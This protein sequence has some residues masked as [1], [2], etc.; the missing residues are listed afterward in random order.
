MKSPAVILL[1][2]IVSTVT[3]QNIDTVEPIVR[4]VNSLDAYGYF[5]FSVVLHRV[6]EGSST[7]LEYLQNTRIIV[8]APNGTATNAEVE[9]TGVLFVC[10]VAQGTC[11]P[12]RGNNNGFDRRLYDVED[13]ADRDQKDNQFLGVSMES[14]DNMFIVCAHRF[15]DRGS[16]GDSRNPLGKCFYTE[17]RALEDFQEFHP[18]RG[19]SSGVGNFGVCQAGSSVALADEGDGNIAIGV[20]APGSY[21][22]RGIIFRRSSSGELDE[23]DEGEGTTSNGW[24]GYSMTKGHI[25]DANREDFIVSVTRTLT[26]I[27]TVNI[28]TNTDALDIVNE[29]QQYRGIQIG[30][31]Y[32]F[33]LA[34]VDLNGDGLDELLVG[35]PMYSR[36]GIPEVGRVYIYRN[37]G[38]NLEFFIHLT[39]PTIEEY[40]RF[41]HSITNLGDINGDGLEDVAIGAPFGKGSGTVYIYHGSVADT[42]SSLTPQQVIVG[43]EITESLTAV[44]SPKGFGYSLASGLDVDGNGL[45]DLVIGAYE[46]QQVFLLRSR[47]V[48]R[49]TITLTSNPAIVNLDNTTCMLE[50]VNYACFNVTA[51]TTFPGGTIIL[52]D[53]IDLEF[54]FIGDRRNAELGLEQRIF[55]NNVNQEINQTV[56]RMLSKGDETCVSETVYVKNGIT[57]RINGFPIELS[58]SGP[59]LNSINVDG[60]PNPTN[61]LNVPTVFV[62]GINELQV[63]T[64]K[65]CEGFVCV[66]D[67]EL[68][69]LNVSYES[70]SGDPPTSLVVGMV[71]NFNVWMTFSNTNEDAFLSQLSFTIPTAQFQFIRIEP[72]RFLITCSSVVRGNETVYTCLIANPLGMDQNRTLAVRLQPTKLLT[73]AEGIINLKFSA[74]SINEEMPNTLQDNN[75]TLP[76]ELSAIADIFIDLAQVDPEQVTYSTSNISSSSNITDVTDLGPRINVSFVIRNS[77]PSTV[78]NIQLSIFWPLQ[79]PDEDLLYYLYPAQR[80]GAGSSTIICETTFINPRRFT[81]PSNEVIDE[82]EVEGGVTTEGK[83]R[84]RRSILFE[85]RKR[86][87][88]KRQE[89]D[90]ISD[91]TINCRTEPDLCVNIVCNILQLGN[92]TAR[93]DI[94]SHLHEEYFQSRSDRFTFIPYANLSIIGSSYIRQPDIHRSDEAEVQI[95]AVTSVPS[96]QGNGSVPLWIIIVPIV[97]GLLFFAVVAVILYFVGFFRLKSKQ[98]KE[99]ISAQIL[100]QQQGGETP[101]DEFST[102]T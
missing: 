22:W 82:D 75:F 17:N 13:N 27:G 60:N 70:S 62:S 74:T 40:T 35:A 88:Q 99:E 97:L 42:I 48:A 80:T 66:P 87:L 96:S 29:N 67:L 73:G 54:T 65:D 92:T 43:S 16:S 72:R 6:G 76:I 101:Y 21:S 85:R 39:A 26:Y 37:V 3:A 46:S 34:A 102:S 7:F 51:C 41:G 19:R 31:Y 2:A 93:V 47:A 28:V 69:F 79:P 14:Q 49:V 71:T 84:R 9:N 98:K 78:P 61:L 77:G 55:F 58:I 23:M 100:E 25:T 56:S 33:S 89:V 86:S 50:S 24:Q 59:E 15:I 36:T 12:L 8:S 94:V 45:N 44:N 90:D 38:G 68:I 63:E 57:D 53:N 1:F 30:E 5:G 11:E 81:I 32:G 52:P 20:G 18:C 91:I 10:P 95:R 83:K 4:S 64:F